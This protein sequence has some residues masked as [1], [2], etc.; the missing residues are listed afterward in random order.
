MMNPVN[1]VNVTSVDNPYSLRAVV[2]SV[3]SEASYLAQTAIESMANVGMDCVRAVDYSSQWISDF[4]HM[5]PEVK[6]QAHEIKGLVD[7][8]GVF[9]SFCEM[10]MAGKDLV[11]TQAENVWDTVDVV[12]GYVGASSDFYSRLDD[13]SV[14][15]LGAAKPAVGGAGAAADL[16][17]GLRGIRAS[18][19]NVE[20]GA[21]G[22]GSAM[23]KVAK[24]VSLA[25]LAVLA[26]ISS[27]FASLAS[28]W[29]ALPLYIL[30]AA[31][32]L[33]AFK[34]ADCFYD[35]LVFPMPMP[36]DVA[37]P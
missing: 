14:I 10:W 35:K 37:M 8:C 9:G 29:T 1:S 12:G 21:A 17:G 22:I 34:V 18:V 4:S 2:S 28:T 30:T 27:C 31:T 20:E 19:V 24:N 25:V 6:G 13:L 26:G 23:L 15:S 33:L 32:S 11:T 3:V 36:V 16:I 5:S 7:R